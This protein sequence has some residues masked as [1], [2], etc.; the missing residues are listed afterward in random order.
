M[1]RNAHRGEALARRLL[2]S[3]LK[4]NRG[5]VMSSLAPKLKCNVLAAA[6]LS[7]G[8]AVN[9]Y[10]QGTS[11]GAGTAGGASAPSQGMSSAAKDAKTGSL[12]AE[13][14]K[15]VEKAAIGGM[16]EVELGQLAQQKA[17]SAQ[18]KEFGARMVQDH[19]KANDELK[20]IATAKGAQVPASIDKKHQRDMEK[21]QK[22]SGAEFDRAYMQHMVAD[23]KEDI[24]LFQKE[25]KSGRDPDLKA[26]ASKSLPVLQEHLKMAQSANDAVK[27]GK[28]GKTAAN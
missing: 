26:F 9:V 6:V 25:A 7:L 3:G 28:T 22:L 8:C 17:S 1:P 24:S 23:H 18:V 12:A 4:I 13:D 15:F 10:A 21:L 2:L 19:G 20:Q 11:G 27:G 14:R 16:L 5:Q